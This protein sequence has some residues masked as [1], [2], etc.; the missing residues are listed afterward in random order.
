MSDRKSISIPLHNMRLSGDL[1]I[2]N[3]QHGLVLYSH[4]SGSSRS[5]PRNAYVSEMLG[6]NGFATLLFDLLTEAEDQDPQMRFNIE[7]LTTR[8]VATTRWIAQQEDVA[9]L[10][11]GYFGASTGTASA[12][13]AAVQLP[14]LV[15][16]IVSRGGRPDLA[17]AELANVK[18]PTLLIV[19]AMD[20]V[21]IDLNRR[22]MER[23]NCIKEMQ[24]VAGASHLFE[25]PG[26]LAEVAQLASEWF[27]A[28]LYTPQRARTGGDGWIIGSASES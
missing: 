23:M 14:D 28:Y 18:A 11:I 4:G 20:S 26:T 12:L 16:A 22:A 15:E 9:G 17:N 6:H 1:F 21:V 10:P 19:G 25:E 24:V 2:P 27:E 7:L 5:S 13:R 3:R 8:L